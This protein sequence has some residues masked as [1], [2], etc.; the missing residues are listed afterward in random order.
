MDGQQQI[1]KRRQ[2][3]FFFHRESFSHRP[4][5]ASSRKSGGTL[6]AKV[7]LFSFHTDE[8]SF[9]KT[10]IVGDRT[11]AT[12]PCFACWFYKSVLLCLGATQPSRKK[13]LFATTSPR[14]CALRRK[15]KQN[16]LAA[17][18]SI[19]VFTFRAFD[20]RI[21]SSYE[22]AS[23]SIRNVLRCPVT[24]RQRCYHAYHASKITCCS[25]RRR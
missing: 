21:H 8:T 4:S 17:K 11:M 6:A 15:T 20:I 13:Q 18:L 14:K 22:R 9:V 23:R 10:F 19:A 2:T 16:L 7:R 12:G 24:T 1:K 25:A 3:E 5:K